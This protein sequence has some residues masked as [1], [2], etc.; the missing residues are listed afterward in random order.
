MQVFPDI[1]F[2][3]PESN[4]SAVY[5]H[6]EDGDGVLMPIRPQFAMSKNYG[7][8]QEAID[9]DEGEAW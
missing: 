2:A 7:I 8:T 9:K 4:V 6:S 5:F 3:K 1:R